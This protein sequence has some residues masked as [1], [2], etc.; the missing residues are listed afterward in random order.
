MSEV[1]AQ[2][3]FGS[4]GAGSMMPGHGHSSGFVNGHGSNGGMQHVSQ[5]MAVQQQAAHMAPEYV[6]PGW[7]EPA[8]AGCHLMGERGMWSEHNINGLPLH[9]WRPERPGL[10]TFAS[11]PPRMLDE[12][13]AMAK[14]EQWT[15]SGHPPFSVLTE[16]LNL[17]FVR[18]VEQG[19]V[20]M[21]FGN[22][23]E[24]EWACFCT[25]LLTRTTEEPIYIVLQVIPSHL[26]TNHCWTM[27]SLCTSEKLCDQNAPWNASEPLVQVP[28]RAAFFEDPFDLLYRP[29]APAQPL[30]YDPNFWEA[31]L[32]PKAA[33]DLA[34]TMS[35]LP[36]AAL[37]PHA[38]KQ[39]LDQAVRRAQR[40]VL[41]NPRLAVPRYDAHRRALQLLFPLKLDPDSSATHLALAVDILSTRRG[42]RSFRAAAVLLLQEAYPSARAVLPIDQAWLGHCMGPVQGRGARHAPAMAANGHRTPHEIKAHSDAPRVPPGFPS[43][44][45]FAGNGAAAANGGVYRSGAAQPAA[46]KSAEPLPQ[47]KAEAKVEAKAAAP[48]PEAEAAANGEG[49]FENGD[50]VSVDDAESEGK[51]LSDAEVA[52]VEVVP[53]VTPWSR[54]AAMRGSGAVP[55]A[56]DKVLDAV[57]TVALDDDDGDNVVTATDLE[58]GDAPT[59]LLAAER[60]P[61]RPRQVAVDIVDGFEVDKDGYVIGDDNCPKL[62][63]A[64]LP[65]GFTKEFFA[66]LL[67]GGGRGRRGEDRAE[68]A[69]SYRAAEKH[70]CKRFASWGDVKQ[71]VVREN[72]HA[73]DKFFCIIEFNEWTDLEARER[74]LDGEVVM[75][76][77]FYEDE[78]VSVK[79]HREKP[80]VVRQQ[81][82]K[83]RRRQEQ[84]ARNAERS[85]RVDAS[86]DWTSDKAGRLEANSD[87]AA[88]SEGKKPTHEPLDPASVEN[89]NLWV[90][91]LEFGCNAK[92]L[93]TEFGAFGAVEK[94]IVKTIVTR[95]G[96]LV[97][98]YAFVNMAAL[99]GA[100]A[101][102]AALGEKYRF[103]AASGTGAKSQLDAAGEGVETAPPPK[104]PIKGASSWRTPR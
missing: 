72:R 23:S 61:V 67:G 20:L 9:G 104:K 99:E 86:K 28:E 35:K 87:E 41:V 40:Q 91:S 12:L 98:S 43:R 51:A 16:Y 81:L 79:I 8:I 80:H 15:L 103:G 76:E 46:A 58:G 66:E 77:G 17:Q 93:Q 25:S 24:P 90:G 1:V 75:F 44:P 100:R 47:A 56:A 34:A 97:P 101:A 42:A 27:Y 69:E 36:L 94:V 48:A 50:D 49:A 26:V 55:D 13:Q 19:S 14:V 33:L 37:A 59:V 64:A 11:V 82:D 102:V 10:F 83:Q 92:S 65:M 32:A 96:A 62:N 57:D 78:F 7:C 74:V 68:V 39:P 52:A 70:V 22:D 2:P 73:Y 60:A 3:T 21:A 30:D 88:E 63:I 84:A 5:Q 18:L 38:R 71:A 4:R 85:D 45:K 31:T 29:P 54:V 6:E 95:K 53:G 89:K